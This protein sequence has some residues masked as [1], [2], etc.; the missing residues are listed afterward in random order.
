MSAVAIT[1]AKDEL[2]KDKSIPA[3]LM[4]ISGFIIN[5]WSGSTAVRSL[6]TQSSLNFL[7]ILMVL[8]KNVKGFEK[9]E[10]QKL[11][12]NQYNEYTNTRIQKT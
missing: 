4:G 5:W 8:E 6:Q 3:N 10:N 9:I 2:V 7:N 11:L 12:T 1:I